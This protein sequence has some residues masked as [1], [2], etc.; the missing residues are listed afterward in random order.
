M[1][2]PVDSYFVYSALPR[3]P[4]GSRGYRLGGTRAHAELGMRR[5]SSWRQTDEAGR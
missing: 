5:R 4:S 1:D 2:D 3:K